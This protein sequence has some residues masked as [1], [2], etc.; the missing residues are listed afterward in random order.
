MPVEVIRRKAKLV[1]EQHDKMFA[2]F[3]A[4]AEAEGQLL[5]A[6]IAVS[7]ALGAICSPIDLG[8]RPNPLTGT[9]IGERRLSLWKGL[10]LGQK[11]TP[12]DGEKKLYIDTNNRLILL[13]QRV[14]G[15]PEITPI[16]AFQAVREFPVER[17]ISLLSAALDQQLRGKSADRTR[18]SAERAQA[19]R[20]I[21]ALLNSS[22]LRKP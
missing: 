18:E 16:T 12:Q 19:V 4:Q 14:T 2:S 5:E 9:N 21:A 11:V 6:V 22:K 8:K 1:G 7:P 13:T 3:E 20:G 17:A 15:D 10:L